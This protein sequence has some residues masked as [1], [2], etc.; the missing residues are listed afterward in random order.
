MKVESWRKIRKLLKTDFLK[1]KH[2]YENKVFDLQKQATQCY[3]AWNKFE[4]DFKKIKSLGFKNKF[5]KKS[6]L[7]Q[8]KTL[9]VE[10]KSILNTFSILL[11]SM[12]NNI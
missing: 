1:I 8:R 10:Y 5:Q 4:I 6:M 9:S 12:K 7:Y 2:I 11:I 3:D